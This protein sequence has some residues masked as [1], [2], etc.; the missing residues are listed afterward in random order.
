MVKKRFIF[1]PPRQV[2]RIEEGV[3]Y[4]EI[5]LGLADR[6]PVKRESEVFSMNL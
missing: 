3:G 5:N 1:K 2:H 4:L 6:M